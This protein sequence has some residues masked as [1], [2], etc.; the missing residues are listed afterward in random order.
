VREDQLSEAYDAV[1]APFWRDKAE[2]HPITFPSAID[3]LQLR[4]RIVLRSP[5][6]AAV[7]IASGRTES[8]IMYKELVYDLYL[9]GCSVFIMDH[10]GQG[11][12]DRILQGDANR[13]IG[14][15]SDFLH[16][17]RDL[18]QF[19]TDFVKPTG[20]R[21][22]VLLGHS[23][24]GCVAS[25]YLE[26]YKQD[27]D[28]AVLAA[29]M[30]QP[31]FRFIPENIVKA[32]LDWK[33]WIG[34]AE[35]YA[36]NR[37]GYDE[38]ATFLDNGLTHSEVRWNLMRREYQMEPVAKLGGPSVLWVKCAAEAAEAA[39]KGAGRVNVPI[40]LLQ[41]GNDTVVKAEGQSKFCERLNEAH[42]GFCKFSPIVGASHGIFLEADTYRRPAL[43]LALEF[44]MGTTTARL[45]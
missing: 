16:Y 30:H 42:P 26:S 22:H 41:A 6:E 44:I 5:R 7:V 31:A 13:Q 14:H 3:R 33:D 8:F 23:M 25:Q 9:A 24:G 27:F 17:V 4:A 2:D 20:H 32:I 19:F 12:S 43:E 1:I 35:E 39:W 45:S 21:R 11:L 18:K 37:S 40:L 34:R 29:P 10:R 15:V 38:T 28:C 36:P